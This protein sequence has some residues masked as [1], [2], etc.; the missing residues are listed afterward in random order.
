MKLHGDL[1]ELLEKR[2]FGKRAFGNNDRRVFRNEQIQRLG[3]AL[4]SSNAT[5]SRRRLGYG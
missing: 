4:D 5:P 1:G 2:V 3:M